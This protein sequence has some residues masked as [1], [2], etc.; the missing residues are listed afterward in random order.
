MTTKRRSCCSRGPV[1]SGWHLV[2]QQPMAICAICQC[3]GDQAP[4]VRQRSTTDAHN[5]DDVG[6]Q[7]VEHDGRR[8]SPGGRVDNVNVGPDNHRYTQQQWILYQLSRWQS[9]PISPERRTDTLL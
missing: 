5:N 6:G 9:R 2:V 1:G 3:R 4:H 8:A 7:R